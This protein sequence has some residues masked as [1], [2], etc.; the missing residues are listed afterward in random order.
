MTQTSLAPWPV[1]A[2]PMQGPPVEALQHLLR[3][4]GSTIAADGK[5]GPMTDAAVKSFQQ[6]RGLVVD[7]KAGPQTWP[8]LIVTVR[9]NDRGEAVRGPQCLCVDVTVA[10]PR[11]QF[12]ASITES[13][14]PTSS[15][16]PTIVT[17]A[18][19][20]WISSCASTNAIAK[21]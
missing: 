14:E 8:K 5:F 21:K 18:P 11:I 9:R 4:H 19:S 7:G 20:I 16:N 2:Q 6:S 13:G 1:I 12:C 17:S 10:F 3:H 15:P